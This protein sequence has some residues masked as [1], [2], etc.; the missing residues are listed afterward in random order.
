MERIDFVKKNNYTLDGL[1]EKLETMLSEN[2]PWGHI[3][4]WELEN[5]GIYFEAVPDPKYDGD[6]SQNGYFLCTDG[7]AD[8][9]MYKDKGTG[10][11][12][13]QSNM[14]FKIVEQ[15]DF[16]AIARNYQKVTKK[17]EELKKEKAALESV[18][19][20]QKIRGLFLKLKYGDK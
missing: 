11:Y 15:S 14:W 18:L 7:V 17:L 13:I 12:Y 4:D 16:E 9:T 6:R 3:E 19:D 2:G 8:V 5:E 10:I 1:K 20:S